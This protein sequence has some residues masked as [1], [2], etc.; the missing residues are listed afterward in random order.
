MSR[1]HLLGLVCAVLLAAGRPAVALE[2]AE[3]GAP[4]RPAAGPAEARLE[5]GRIIEKVATLHDPQQ[6]YALYLPKAYTPEKKW[7][8][9]YGFSPAARGTDPVKLFAAAAEKYG[10]IV[11]GSNNSQNGP[12]EPIQAAIEAMLKDT[13]ARLAIDWNRRYATGFSG[14]ARVA[15]H[16]ALSQPPFAGVIAC[17]AGMPGYAKPP[18]RGAKL[19]V[20]GIIGTRDFNYI[21]LLRLEDTLR[22]LELRQR[23]TIFDGEHR[24]PSPE[25]C[26]A[27]LRYMELVWLVDQ[28]RSGEEAVADI[29]DAELADAAKLLEAKGQFLRGYGRYEELARLFKDSEERRKPVLDRI[30]AVEATERYKRERKAQAELAALKVEWAAIPDAEEQFAR[31]VEGMAGFAAA[32]P[33]ADAGIGAV[34]QLRGMA[35]QFATGGSQLHAAGRYAEACTYLKRARL[36]L[37]KDQ[38]VAYNLACAQARAGRKDEALKSFAESVELG[39][40]DLD[41]IKKDP[42]L[43]SLRESEEYKKVIEKLAAGAAAG[44]AGLEAR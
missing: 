4:E 11:V 38:G 18:E 30:A 10:W 43:D 9:L 35:F 29:L 32:N 1:L 6:S 36:L 12:H 42:D 2:V 34:N 16:L 33:D 40:R 19:A 31:T 5:T 28:G 15:F 22:K 20:C 8:V 7:P 13:G 27:A 21:E 44:G 17:G 23:L 3:P 26:G 25:L 37:P 41:H 14:G 24:W 39:F